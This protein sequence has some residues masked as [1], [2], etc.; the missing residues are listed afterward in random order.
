M[1]L[2]GAVL[3]EPPYAVHRQIEPVAAGVLDGKD[4]FLILIRL[5]PLKADETSD[6]MITVDHKIT[7]FQV[8][9]RQQ[10]AGDPGPLHR[11]VRGPLTEDLAVRQHHQTWDPEPCGEVS[12]GDEERPSYDAT[13]SGA[14]IGATIPLSSMISLSRSAWATDARTIIVTDSGS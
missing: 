5:L 4:V 11:P 10:E 12:R 1:P 14:M 7:G 9:K 13:V 6:P 2:A 8:V 3:L